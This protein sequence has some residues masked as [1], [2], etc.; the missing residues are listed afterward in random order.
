MDH[1]AV[2]RADET[3]PLIVDSQPHDQDPESSPVLRSLSQPGITSYSTEHVLPIALLAALAMAS[4]AAT[5]YFAY[6]TLLCKDPTH[7]QDSE[8]GAFAVLV[9]V[10]TCVATLFGMLVLGHLQKLSMAN[11]EAGLLLWIICRSM[12]V[13]MLILGGKVIKCLSF[14]P[15]NLTSI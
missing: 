13:V 11:P 8:T 14:S 1:D 3:V 2:V 6:A 4:T 7:C 12:S 15:G 10:A 5:A 9:A